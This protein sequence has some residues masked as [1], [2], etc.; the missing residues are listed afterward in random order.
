M[1]TYL[2]ELEN[3]GVPEIHARRLKSKEVITPKSDEKLIFP[4]AVGKIELFGGVQGLRTSTLRQ[5]L[6]KGA[7]GNRWQ[8]HPERGDA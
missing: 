6:R 1:V 7:P 8:E 2:E 3:L 4:S 5:D